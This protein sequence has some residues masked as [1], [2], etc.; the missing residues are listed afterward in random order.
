MLQKVIFIDDDPIALLL[1]RFVIAKSHFAS[2]I[3]TLN[4]G[5]EAIN[6]LY[7]SDVLE[8]NN[9]TEDLIIFLDLNMPIM[10]GWEFLEKFKTE[11]YSDYQNVK[12]V[13]LSSS[14]DPD[15]IQK[16]KNFCMVIDFMSKPIT[17]EILEAV[18]AKIN[19]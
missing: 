18:L 7:R 15:D 11:L 2:E 19:S 17:K 10:D 9:T 13:L 8:K 1:S 3:V 14:I 5:Q 16:A 12:I 4:D 6:Y